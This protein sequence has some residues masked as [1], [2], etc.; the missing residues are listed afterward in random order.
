MLRMARSSW[1]RYSIAVITVVVALILTR[2]IWELT[3]PHLYPL[4]LA[5][6]MVSSW[7]GGIVPGLVAIAL[8][9]V[10]VYFFIPP[11]YSLT[12]DRV[13]TIGGL[14]QFVL[15][16]LLLVFLNA[17]LRSAQ[18]RAERHA[19]EARH[20][21][22]R[23]RQSE[24][25]YR[26]L[27]E[28]LT[29]YAVFMLDR[30][31]LITSWNAGA[32]RILG[33]REAEI[34]GQP[35][36]RIFTPEAIAQRIPEQALKNAATKGMSKDERWHVRK[37]NSRFWADGFITAVRDE[38][39]NLRGFAK[40]LQDLTDRK[41]AEEEREQLLRRE[42]AARA[43]A[44]AANRTKDDFLAVVSH[45]LRTPMT[46]IVGWAGMWR[47]GMLDEERTALAIETIERN[48]NSQMQ[49]IEDLLD[50]SRIVKSEISLNFSRV[51]LVRVTM[52][53]IEAMQPAAD[54]KGIHLE[55]KIA[56]VEEVS[57]P[58][59][60]VR[61]DRDRLQQV[62]LNLLSNAIKFTPQSGRVEVRLSLV[63]KT[64]TRYAQIQVSD[65]GVGIAPEFLPHAFDRF[66]Q[67]DSTSARASKGLGL[68]LAI[69]HHLVKLH[70]GIIGVESPG[71]GQGA[72]F[73][74]RLPVWE[75]L[76][77]VAEV[78]GERADTTISLTGLRVL[79]V[80]DDRDA[81]QWMRVV[82]EERG[83]EAIAV[84]SV[85]A[86][87]EVLEQ[88]RPDVLVSDIGMPGE[89]GYTLIRKLRELEPEIGGRIPA[90]AL[91]AYARVEDYQKALAEGF[92]L[93]IAKPIRAAELV[94]I[95]ASLARRD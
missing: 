42:R 88:Q 84:G 40:I 64:T 77:E 38:A 90:V 28:G 16:A 72:T 95:V 68:G 91:T 29:N 3:A 24:E 86:A 6:V 60:L 21:Y 51:D 17:R 87:L 2:S 8:A 53:A 80:D 71:K 58:S 32:E 20:N 13:D 36:S 30:N 34:I 79:V 56:P 47:A 74:V 18:Q 62:V 93:H 50:I 49:L 57:S 9:V 12:V 63:D 73:T 14:V 92:Q 11:L 55:L 35:V 5:A 22:D 26:L 89:D 19:I 82:L 43:E 45:E 66:R 23:L 1:N 85:G 59:F 33:Y 83:A 37:D 48:A 75:K 41:Q 61:G 25:R 39:G 81:R 46:A 44:E 4:F 10:C 54:A 67:A 69:A 94:A 78:E 27:V 7:Y 70:G 65:T 52:A 15:V 76:E 31:G